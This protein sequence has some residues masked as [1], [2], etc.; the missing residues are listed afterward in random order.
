MSVGIAVFALV[1]LAAVYS[2]FFYGKGTSPGE[3]QAAGSAP[4]ETK[5]Q[6]PEPVK[7]PEPV[8]PSEKVDV[9]VLGSELEGLYLARAA[10]DEGLKV[11]VLDP[12]EAFGGQVL[13]GEMLFLDETRDDKYQSLVQ[14]RAKELF[15]G[16]RNGK[17]RKLSEFTQY[18]DK[19]KKD[20]PVESGIKIEDIKQ[21]P[22]QLVACHR[23]RHL[24]RQERSQ[25][26]YQSRLL[27]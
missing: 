17:I 4:A 15:D 27:G 5:A 1:A 16:F 9:V 21:I 13:Q 7:K 14:G 24:H 19:L 6:T 10:A 2:V 25:E 23:I 18:F 20:I 26:K 3:R 11:K 12:R 8:I 22:G